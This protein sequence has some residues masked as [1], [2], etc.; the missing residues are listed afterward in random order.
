MPCCGVKVLSACGKSRRAPG[1]QRQV[2]SD[3]R[4]VRWKEIKAAES[5]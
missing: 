2:L 3:A 1:D 5:A 4:I